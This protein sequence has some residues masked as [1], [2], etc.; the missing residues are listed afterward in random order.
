MSTIGQ[1]KSMLVNQNHQHTAEISV[2][3]YGTIV[4]GPNTGEYNVL[5]VIETLPILFAFKLEEET[6]TSW[7]N[8]FSSLSFF[9]RN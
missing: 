9:S 8:C 1:P 3:F 7:T 4:E 6:V 5:L 2:L